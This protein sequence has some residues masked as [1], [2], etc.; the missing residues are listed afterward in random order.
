MS[1]YIAIDIGGTRMRAATYSAN[2]LTPKNINRI[3]TRKKNSPP[4]ERL[5]KLI[6]SVWPEDNKVAAIG[7]AV[8]GP[9][10]C[11]TGVL[12]KAP[13]IPE[14]TGLSIVEYLQ[15]KFQVP[16]QLGNDANLAALGEWKFGAGRGHR[17]MVYLTISTGIGSGVIINDQLFAGA[18][19][20]ASELGH[21]M[22]LPDGPLCGCGVRG[23]LEALA[24]GTA[25]AKWVAEQISKGAETSIITPP[26]DELIPGSLIAEAA[27][28]GDFL[29]LQAFNRAG[30][31]LGQAIADFLHIFNPTILVL[32][33]G[34][35]QSYDLFSETLHETIKTHV[36]IPNYLDDFS[37]AIAELGDDVGLMGA[38]ALARESTS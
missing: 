21:T 12:E 25:I 3:K 2:S 16:I 17:H 5:I 13:N 11:A 33:G 29:A 34:V 38:L 14:L 36:M 6:T 30:K 18:K 32:G 20:F 37:I 8:P 7:I 26:A 15:N 19:G 28:Q 1:T 22:L 23:H 24:S 31:F 10:N 9:V 4:K 27:N 35:S